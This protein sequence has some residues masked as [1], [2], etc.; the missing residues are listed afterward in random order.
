VYF[1]LNIG[2]QLNHGYVF[3]CRP[4]LLSSLSTASYNKI[5]M[6]R[7]KSKISTQLLRVC[8][9]NCLPIP[10]N[11]CNLH[12]MGTLLWGPAWS[13]C[14]I[15]VQWD[16]KSIS[17]ILSQCVLLISELD[18]R[19][20]MQFNINALL[21][22]YSYRIPLE[23]GNLHCC[24]LIWEVHMFCGAICSV[25]ILTRVILAWT[26]STPPHCELVLCSLWSLG[27]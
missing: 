24:F 26:Y 17:Y 18:V 21:K 4:M 7:F 8:W 10:S 6:Q 3:Q 9:H 2:T 15:A 16:I 1:L 14:V 22:G 19:G 23:L 20:V 27:R 11:L 5:T 12:L 13:P 25:N